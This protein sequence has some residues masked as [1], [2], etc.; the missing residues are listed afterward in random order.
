MSLSSRCCPFFLLVGP[1][2]SGFGPSF[3]GFGPSFLGLALRFFL[4]VGPSFSGVGPSFSDLFFEGLALPSGVWPFLLKVWPFLWASQGLA[5]P[6]GGLALPSL[7][8]PFHLGF[9]FF[10]GIGPSSSFVLTLEEVNCGIAR[11]PLTPKVF[12]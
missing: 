2:F 10:G 8:W 4:G 11:E 5:I 1:F 3:S 12:F 6:C 7:G 9:V